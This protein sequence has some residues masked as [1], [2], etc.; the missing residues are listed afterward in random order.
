MEISKGWCQAT[1]ILTR[2]RILVIFSLVS[3]KA[4]TLFGIKYT[5]KLLFA[6]TPRSRIKDIFFESIV[7]FDCLQNMDS[8][9]NSDKLRQHS[10]NCSIIINI[11]VQVIVTHIFTYHCNFEC[12]HCYIFICAI[13]TTHANSKSQV[14]GIFLSIS[15]FKA[16]CKSVFHKH[17]PE[18]PKIL[19]LYINWNRRQDS[20]TELASW[21]VV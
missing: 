2:L 3:L 16:L 14:T 17:L 4:N 6:P 1:W 19:R 9:S 10:K 15:W 21:R 11:Y 5:P 13:P 12:S 18:S 20:L 7:I 8:S